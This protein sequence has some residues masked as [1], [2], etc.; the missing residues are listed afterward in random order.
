MSTSSPGTEAPSDDGQAHR[1]PQGYHHGNLR[2]A[3]VE[4]GLSLLA[5]DGS[6]G[7]SLREAAR[8]AG[9]TVNASYR[10]FADKQ[11]LVAA[12]SAEG[13]RRLGDRL[14]QGAARGD[15]P[16]SRLLEAAR[17]YVGFACAQPALFR[18][19]FG[20][21]GTSGHGSELDEATAYANAVLRE[22][23]AAL[24]GPAAPPGAVDLA[25]LR[26]WALAH[27]ISHLAI[28][29][30]I[31]AGAPHFPHLVEALLRAWQPA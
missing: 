30:K 23:V 28:D 6:T 10:H 31:D 4:A 11:A 24:L 27:G 12:I 16:E 19:M 25:V 5:R 9:V 26:A 14:R 1:A 7:F 20:R 2:Q 8:M 21:F 15:S 13:F 22:G 18:L 29:G 17:E 3:L